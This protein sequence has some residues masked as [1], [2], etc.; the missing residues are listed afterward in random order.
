MTNNI[1]KQSMGEA[2]CVIVSGTAQSIP[3]GQYCAIA[4][5]ADSSISTAFSA[6]EAPLMSGTQTGIT[7]PAGYVILTPLQ[8]TGTS[9]GQITGTA[10]FYKA[11]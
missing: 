9:T 2:G 6:S 8:I 11:L 5:A 4:F 3:A 10:I 1:D 7:W